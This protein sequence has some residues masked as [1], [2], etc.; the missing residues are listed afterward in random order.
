M[1]PFPAPVARPVPLLPSA[2]FLP[3]GLGIGPPYAV[4]LLLAGV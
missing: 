1:A 2:L 4:G 3:T